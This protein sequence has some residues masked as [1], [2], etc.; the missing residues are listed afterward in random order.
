MK[1]FVVS[2]FI[3]FL[4]L[5]T[6]S[7]CAPSRSAR[8]AVATNTLTNTP[9]PAKTPTETPTPV[10]PP[11]ATATPTPTRTSTPTVVRDKAFV[12]N[13][14][15]S[16]NGVIVGQHLGMNGDRYSEFVAALA[17][18]TGKFPGLVGGDY[19][20]GQTLA[21]LEAQNQVLLSYWQRGGLVTIY[22]PAD[23]PWTGGPKDDLTGRNLIDLMNPTSAAY[24][25]WM[26]ELAKI[27]DALE[28][29][30][31]Q[32]VIVLWR[33]FHEMTH[34][35]GAWWDYGAHPGDPDPFVAVWRHEY[36]YFTNVRGLDNLIWV[37]AAADT[38]D[39]L[40]VDFLYPGSAYVD[41]VGIDL[42]DNALRLT[43][44]DGGY[45]RLLALGKPFVFSECGPDTQ[46]DGTFD[47]R[48]L[49]NSIKANYPATRYFLVWSSWTGVKVAIVD[50]SHATELMND[51][52][53]ITLDEM[54]APVPPTPTTPLSRTARRTG[55]G[56]QA[57]VLDY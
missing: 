52:F 43:G 33:P 9:T 25:A 8:L 22:H 31:R 24:A 47:N 7:A 29:L 19:G 54:N 11:T 6:F 32:G 27:G 51:A 4:V 26:T 16:A 57:E 5:V 17:T 40:R 49:V 21:Q 14:I 37:Y 3:A 23:N 18:E 15:T 45:H 38:E 20:H 39:W 53:V 30:K 44:G 34:G 48:I 36:N 35:S 55:R 10:I 13:Q 46:V 50:N 56:E 2:V 41:M 12:L 28:D 42:Y 1:S